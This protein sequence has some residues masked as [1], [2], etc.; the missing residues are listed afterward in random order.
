M[1]TADRNAQLGILGRGAIYL[2]VSDN[3]WFCCFPEAD[4]G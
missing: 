3:H 2:E 4:K 1:L